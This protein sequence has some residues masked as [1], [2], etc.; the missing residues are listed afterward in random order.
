MA[1][2]RPRSRV[3]NVTGTGKSVHRRGSGLG[4]G[5][6]GKPGRTGGMTQNT[7][8]MTSSRPASG[9]RTTRA[10]GGMSKL[11]ILLLVVLLGGGTGLT[12]LLGGSGGESYESPY[13]PQ[14]NA[15][16]SYEQQVPTIDLE[17]L[18]GNLGGGTVSTGWTGSNTTGKLDT[19]VADGARE[20]FTRLKG[21]GKDTMTILVYLCGTDLESRSKM[22]T[23][24][25]QEMLDANLSDKI[26]LIVYTGGCRQWQ[27]NVLS[28]RTNQIWQVLD[29][30]LKCLKEDAGNKSMTDPNTLASFLKWGIQNYPADRTALIFWDHGGGSVSGYGYDEK[31][32]SSGSMDLAEIDQALTSVGTK[33]DF[34]GFDACLMAT[35]ETA[36]MLAKHADYL[37]ASEETEPGIG[38]YYTNWLTKLSKNTSLSTLEI[39]KAIIDD[40]VDTCAQK[41]R[42]QSTTLSIIDLA[43][44]ELTIPDALAA[45]SADTCDLIR[46]EEY[47]QVSNARSGSR[48]FGSSSRIDQVDLVHLAKNMGTDE[49][50]ALAKA[51]LG[52][53]KYNRTSSNMTNAYGLSIYF[54]FRKASM[55]DTAV[56]TYEQI[57]MDED[58]LRC[59]QAFASMEVSGQAASGGTATALPSLMDL[60]G[61]TG[62]NGNA[63][64][65]EELLGTFLGGDV[66]GILGLMEGNTDFLNGRVLEEDQM[67]R[68][69]TEHSFDGSSLVWTNGMITLPED[70]WA[71]VQTLH[72]NM[73]YDDGT[74]YIDLGM[75]TV[76]DF[77]A[78]GNLLAPEEITWIAINEQPVAYYHEFTVDDGTHYSITGRVPVF[79]N[80]ERAELILEFS[81]E[82]PY[83]SVV[84]VRRVYQD[85]ET[86]TLPKAMATVQVGDTIDFICDYYSYSG[87]YLDSYMLGEQLIVDGVLSI[88]DVYVDT[89]AARLTYCFT[90]IYNR[91]YWTNPVS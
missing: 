43:E 41:C 54:P 50:N 38:W 14:Q 20:K 32:A 77:D 69:I 42:G 79:Y 57:G 30:G 18:L 49:G 24:D 56:D 17:S 51:L 68:Y 8:P 25:L 62:S 6:V 11:I 16:Q 91:Q 5:P 23:A 2:N 37:I 63:Q 80:G 3:K 1:T 76:Y 60:M 74:G 7:S 22:A 85:G 64:M 27:N 39:G 70:Q 66:S 46:N 71:L 87:E 86:D 4:T 55:V 81:D 78:F 19:T 47:A 31:F 48:E 12:G 35:T 29:E 61:S 90:D 59:I 10:G 88:S 67:A 65:I 13:Q 15:N 33:F 53:V 84:G 89:D 75:D 40:F 28:S 44:A 83:G 72:A 58:Y 36:L 34:V 52:A 9:H 73:F 26:N 45:F 21:N 82:D